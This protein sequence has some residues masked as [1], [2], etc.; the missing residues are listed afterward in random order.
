MQGRAPRHAG[1]TGPSRRSSRG[2]SRY[3]GTALLI[4][5]FP[6]LSISEAVGAYMTA[7]AI[8]LAIGLSGCFDRLMDYVPKGVASGMM[9]GILLPFGLNAFKGAN[10]LP[11]LSCGMIAAC[12]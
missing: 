10:T 3:L 12:L 1:P 4:T 11:L 5:L 2:S 9:A 7:A 6:G 8:L